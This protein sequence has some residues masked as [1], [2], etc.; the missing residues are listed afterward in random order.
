VSTVTRSFTDAD[1]LRFQQFRIPDELLDLHDIRRVTD[2]EARSQCGIHF[3]GDL[4][5][6]AWP[7]WG[8]NDAIK[9]YRVRRD[10]PEI[11]NGKPKAK[12]VQSLDR[13]H[14]FFERSSRRWLSDTSVPVIFVEAY[15]S[16]LAVAALAE[17]TGR[18]F[19]VIGLG[20]CYGWRG[21]I[22]K[23]TNETGTRV[24]EKGPSPDL[25]H[26]PF[27]NNRKVLCCLDSNVQ[28]NSNVQT[29]EREFKRELEK[30]GAVVHLVRIAEEPG[31][32]GPDDYIAL[33]DDQAFCRILDETA[34]DIWPEPKPVQTAL[35][36]VPQLS[37]ALIP[38]PFRDWLT[39]ISERMGCPLDFVAT[40]ALVVVG[41]VIGAGC[42]VRP[43][44]KDDWT[45]VPNL[46]G[47]VVGR[48][49]V[50]MK[51]PALQ[52]AMRPLEKLAAESK[53][54]HQADQ[55][56]FEAEIEMTKARKDAARD[57]MRVAAKGLKKGDGATIDA[58]QAKT[59]YA[60]I[61]APIAPKWRRY[62]TNDATIE[63]LGE[64]LSANPRGLLVFR[65]ELI[66]LLSQWE[67][68]GHQGDR[69]FFLEA[70]NGL[71]S[72]ECDRIGRGSVRI[73]NACVSILGGIQP[74]KLTSYLHS[75][76][77]GNEND[78]LLQRLQLLVFPDEPPAKAI[79][80]RY[81]NAQAR[82]RGYSIIKKL[83]EIDFLQYGAALEGDAQIPFLRFDDAAQELFYAWF[84]DLNCK[85]RDDD[86]PI[87]TEHLGK[88]RK[89]LPSLALIFHLIDIADGQAPG[90]IPED[91]L[92]RAV[93]WC[94]YLEQHARRIYGLVTDIAIEAAAR[95]ARR[96]QAGDLGERFTLR[97]VYRCQWSLLTEKDVCERALEYLEDLGWLRIEEPTYTGGRPRSTEYIVN[98]RLRS[99]S[100]GSA[101]PARLE[102][103]K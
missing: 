36:P 28:S 85:L 47:G 34:P 11:E 68:E 20:G 10:N 3:R 16:A 22:G 12:W 9:G 2:N 97:E 93:Q 57:S 72:H 33:H 52:E 41:S 59:E 50:M 13:P 78:G 6:V 8:P 54:A 55:K 42:G 69:A 102:E 19:I 1:S 53:D 39:D 38:E 29:A 45:V 65:D 103:A 94:Y 66:G 83:A 14:L 77:R 25:D 48:P 101:I 4:S 89:L 87:V 76:M 62:K 61:E 35:R 30:R 17:R 81:P 90:P 7:I 71:G 95:L 79:V 84:D 58:M 92:K 82:A 86:E 46:W 40:S 49:S 63:K 100:F 37:P 27:A 24:D 21:T 18:R 31:V 56:D 98:P 51:T 23:T 43:K 99:V 60:S 15:P 26:I 73:E 5:G 74:A 80:D 32:N 64:L 91:T 75:S 70:W 96:I 88:F 44:Q 67:R